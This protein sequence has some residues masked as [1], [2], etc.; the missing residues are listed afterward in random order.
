MCVTITTRCFYGLPLIHNQNH[1]SSAHYSW[2]IYQEKLAKKFN[3]VPRWTLWIGDPGNFCKSFFV[4]N[5]YLNFNFFFKHCRVLSLK[6][7][8]K[9]LLK[10]DA[11]Q[12]KRE[13]KEKN[14]NK[15]LEK[16]KQQLFYFLLLLFYIGKFIFC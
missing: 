4:K 5:Y 16:V 6:N 7:E 3:K 14:K 12:L 1:K 11:S 15:K 2:N 9:I 13:E 8:T 10:K